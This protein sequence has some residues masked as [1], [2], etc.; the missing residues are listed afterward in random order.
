MLRNISVICSIFL[1]ITS[2][3]LDIDSLAKRHFG[4]DAPWYHDRIPFFESNDVD[5]TDVYYYRWRIFR[6]HQRDLGAHGFI[7]TEFL[8]DVGWQT[9]P[10][11][12]LNDATGFH[13]QE[14]RWCRDRRFKEDYANF[15]YS[16]DSQTRQFSESMAAAVWQGY[17]VDGVAADAIAKLDAMKRVYEAWND[18]FDSSKG[19]YWVEPLRDATEYTISSIDATDGVD[20]FTGGNS[21]RPSIN[22]YQ[23]ANAKAIANLASLQGNTQAVVDDYNKKASSIKSIVQDKLWNSTFEHFIDRFQVNNTFVRYWDFI[24]GR[25]LVGFVPWTHDL[26]DDKVNFAQAWKHI[27]DTS[28]LAGPHGLRTVEPSYQYYMRQYR[29][30]GPKPECQW[31]GPVWPFQTTQVL[32]GL[33]NFLDHY[34]NGVESAV[35]G[36]K[37]YTSLLQQYAKLHYNPS[38][39]GILDL[40]EDYYPDSGAPIVGLKRSPHYFHSGYIDL[41]LTGLVGIRASAEDV[42]EVNPLIDGSII[43]YFR[44]ERVLYHGHDV[45]VQWDTDGSHYGARGLQLEVDGKIVASSPTLKR[46]IFPISRLSPPAISRPIAKSIQLQT[47]IAFPKGTVS[48]PNVSEAEI[49]SAIDGRIFFFPEIDVT[50]GWSTPPGNTS[51]LW[52]A[53]DFGSSTTVE[54]AEIAFFAD[55]SQ[56]F[57]VPKSYR[58]Q[59]LGASGWAEVTDAVYA[60]PVANGI[61]AATWKLESTGKVRLVFRP[62]DGLKV[63]LVEFKVF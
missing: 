59:V 20:G 2:A 22:S 18:S 46:L 45:A 8:N 31:N 28:Q 5:L 13:I 42:L 48:V 52:F 40:E 32:T 26:P 23:Y 11:A 25:E 61:T 58:V 43:T 4:N 10:W 34:P 33:A 9:N 38:R 6:A 44:A 7:S 1:A 54:R 24:R 27:L 47:T 12:S 50:N 36:N 51:E 14:G 56:G 63:R 21:F 3:A 16:S 53:I 30:E 55:A 49:Q 29:Y 19:L 60:G 15:I 39:G 17:L 37:A 62:K 35:I 41:I 57:D